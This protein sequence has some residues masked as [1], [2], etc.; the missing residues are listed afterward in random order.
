MPVFVILIFILLL[1]FLLLAAVGAGVRSDPV[2]CSVYRQLA[3]AC[4]G[5]FQGRPRVSPRVT[6]SYEGRTVDVERVPRISLGGLQRPATR[7]R[8]PWPDP[9]LSG[10]ISHPRRLACPP[11]DAEESVCWTGDRVFDRQY[12]VISS[13]PSQIL[14]GLNPGVRYLAERLRLQPRAGPLIIEIRRGRLEILKL[15]EFGRARELQDFVGCS[16]QLFDQLQLS[17]RQEICF[18]EQAAVQPLAGVICAVCAG[19]IE[20][21]LVFCPRCKTAVHRDCWRFIGKCATYG[22]G[23][24]EFETPQTAPTVVFRPPTP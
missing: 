3:C 16:L 5:T 19:V 13:D 10:R 6:F 2:W 12:A 20:R 7:F 11:G 9:R 22:C 21:D 23:Q 1:V 18:L 17:I 15:A 4:G 8:I 24:P 14:R